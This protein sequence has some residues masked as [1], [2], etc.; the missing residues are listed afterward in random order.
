MTFKFSSKFSCGGIYK[1]SLDF[2]DN[3]EYVEPFKRY[4]Q[5]TI[6]G[7]IVPSRPRP[8]PD[9]ENIYFF[10][11]FFY[12]THDSWIRED[13]EKENIWIYIWNFIRYKT[14]LFW[15]STQLKFFDLLS[16][17]EIFTAQNLAMWIVDTLVM[18]QYIVRKCFHFSY[19]KHIYLTLNHFECCRGETRWSIHL[20]QPIE[21]GFL[22]RQG[23]SKT[24]SQKPG[25]NRKF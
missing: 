21:N 8:R 6:E 2:G 4:V 1:L 18:I 25:K 13:M 17:F 9:R 7:Y 24:L 14:K 23:A 5:K 15:I 3:F 22:G 12:L 10:V 19:F 16:L 11:D 20:F